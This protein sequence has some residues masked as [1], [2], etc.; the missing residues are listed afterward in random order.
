MVSY[1]IFLTVLSL[2]ILSE[3]GDVVVSVRPHLGVH[4]AKQVEHLV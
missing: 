1:I 3:D 2:D 4:D